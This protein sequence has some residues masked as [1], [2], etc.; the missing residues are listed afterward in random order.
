MYFVV[1]AL[2]MFALPTLSV[3]I[4]FEAHPAPLMLL[5]GKWFVFWAVG[6]R[7]VMA[8]LRQLFQPGFTAREIF[9]LQGDEALTLVR[10]LGVSN[11]AVGVVGL[12]A[13]AIPTFVLPSAVTAGVFYGVAGAR[14]MLETGRSRNQTLAMLSDLF[15]FAVLA[16]FTVAQVARLG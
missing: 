6:V 11:F 4:E 7:L 12:A 13:V 1:V 10:E 15:V 16:T 14:H 9:H 5:V 8:G 2:T 3:A